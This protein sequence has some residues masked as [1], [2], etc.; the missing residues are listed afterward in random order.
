MPVV[1][2][3]VAVLGERPIANAFGIGVCGDR[4]ARLGQ[5]RLDT[6]AFDRAVQA[7]GCRPRG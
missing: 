6:E 7:R 3:T 5:V 4:D 2:Q 1:A